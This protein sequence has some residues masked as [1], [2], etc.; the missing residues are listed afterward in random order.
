MKPRDI[1]FQSLQF[2]QPDICPYYIWIDDAMV[3]PLAEKY[4][5]DQFIGP[6]GSTRTFGG[7]YTAMSEILP[8]PVVEHGDCYIDGYG[9]TF[10][11]GST[12]HV[13]KPEAIDIFEIK[14]EFGRDLCLMGG[15]STQHTLLHGTSEEVRKEV[16]DCLTQMTV[17]PGKADFPRRP[18]GECRCPDRC[19]F[20]STYLDLR[21]GFQRRPLPARVTTTKAEKPRR[22][23]P[24]T[25]RTF[26]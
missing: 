2:Q 8:R 6:A 14:R 22:L 19:F 21:F 15:I 13:E 18:G 25:N 12:L 5:E 9:V 1:L 26:N 10:R 11:R 7:S 3:A 20:G 4:G 17:G 16:R 24:V 23:Q